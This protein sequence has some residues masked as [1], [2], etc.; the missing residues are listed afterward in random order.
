[1]RY[2]VTLDFVEDQATPEEAVFEVAKYID[3]MS[4]FDIVFDVVGEDGSMTSMSLGEIADL[5]DE[6]NIVRAENEGDED[7]SG[8]TK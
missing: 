6:G 3:S 7:E 5:D 8:G 1:M 2:T 4:V